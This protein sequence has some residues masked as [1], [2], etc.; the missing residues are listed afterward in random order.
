MKTADFRSDTVTLPTENMYR[1]MMSA[2]LG[3]DVYDDDPTVKELEEYAASLLGKDAA[4]FVP[5][6]TFANQLAIMTHTRRGDEV[7]VGENT[8]ILQHEV[9]GAAVLSGVN[10]RAVSPDTGIISAEA[11]KRCIRDE[12]IHFP[13]TGLIC[14]ENA[15][16]LGVVMPEKVM[17]DIKNLA[18]ERNIPVH[19]DGARFF[20]AAT[21]LEL[22]YKLMASYAHSI[23]I[24]LSKGLCAPAGSLLVGESDFIGRAKKNRKLL[25]GGMRQVGI[26]GAAGLI[27][28]KE[29]IPRLAEDHDNARYMAEK[30]SG[31]PGISVMNN[32]LD[33]NMVFFTLK[34]ASCS[35]DDL[36]I[37]LKGKG[38]K[39]NGPEGEEWRFAAN[40]GIDKGDIDRLVSCLADFLG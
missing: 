12:D 20:N 24:C 10:L 14:V 15:H 29:M 25:G 33:I 37:K 4:L 19:M 1:A 3:D 6:G 35:N 34:G 7:I 2:V 13:R 36:V 30:L 27:A 18:D 28:L 23:N 8:H 5:T 39:V 9:G 11:V 16:S 32:R 40:R 38:F 31:L 26:L 22:D 21:A 17:K